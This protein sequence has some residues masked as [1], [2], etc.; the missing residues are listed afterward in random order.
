MSLWRSDRAS[1]RGRRAYSRMTKVN[2]ALPWDVLRNRFESDDLLLRLDDEV[3]V[4]KLDTRPAIAKPYAATKTAPAVPSA[5]LCRKG[6][7]CE[8][9]EVVESEWT[10]TADMNAMRDTGDNTLWL[11]SVSNWSVVVELPGEVGDEVEPGVDP[12]EVGEI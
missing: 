11:T 8:G 6:E 3:I 4:V 1:K 10:K 9:C 12:D 5:T 2:A 7:V